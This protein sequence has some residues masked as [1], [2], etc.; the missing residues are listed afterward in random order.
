[1][2]Q[3]QPTVGGV[4]S[5]VVLGAIRRLAMSKP[6]R[7]NQPTV[8]LCGVCLRFWSCLL[9]VMD[10]YLEVKA[11]WARMILLPWLPNYCDHS[12][13]TPS[14]HVSFF[15]SV[16]DT[17]GRHLF[18]LQSLDQ[19]KVGWA[20][21]SIMAAELCDADRLMVSRRK[22]EIHR[23]GQEQDILSKDTT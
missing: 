2:W 10:C 1:M 8:S 22:K 19:F 6:W 15:L 9:F 12:V 17:Q 4:T 18:W 21:Q 11:R 7:A 23:K 3:A 20:K 5:G 14:N 16:T 13:F